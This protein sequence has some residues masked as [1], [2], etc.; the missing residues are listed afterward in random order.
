M[1]INSHG[2]NYHPML[3]I[4][5]F[6]FPDFHISCPFEISTLISCSNIK[7][8][9]EKWNYCFF[10]TK[11]ASHPQ[12]SPFQLIASASSHN[13]S[14]QKLMNSLIPCSET[15]ICFP[16]A[17]LFPETDT[18]VNHAN[19]SANIYLEST[20]DFYWHYLSQATHESL[21]QNHNWSLWFHS[22]LI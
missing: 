2:F 16:L 18:P 9:V 21:Q 4:F 11:L 3:M 20:S 12:S 6:V 14:S 19:C 22:C 17:L 15:L 1:F 8:H 13:F 5:K 10:S 7:Q